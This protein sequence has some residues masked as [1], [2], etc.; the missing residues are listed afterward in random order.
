MK[1]QYKDGD[2]CLADV[3]VNFL[4]ETVKVRNYTKDKILR[5]FG[6][7]EN[8]TMDDFNWLLESRCVPRTRHNIKE[9]LKSIGLDFYDPLEIV[10]RTKGYQLEDKLT[11]EY[12]GDIDDDDNEI[13]QL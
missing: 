6:V 1:F 9:V 12:V 11:F 8:P 3:Y 5:P 2:E 7:C 13:K 4:S 10:M